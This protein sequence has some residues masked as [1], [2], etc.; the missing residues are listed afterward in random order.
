MSRDDRIRHVFFIVLINCFNRADYLVWIFGSK[1]LII[2]DN[3]KKDPAS[4]TNVLPIVIFETLVLK[5]VHTK[6]VFCHWVITQ[7]RNNGSFDT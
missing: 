1:L 4:Y 7:N 3:Q 2:N 5:F 6:T